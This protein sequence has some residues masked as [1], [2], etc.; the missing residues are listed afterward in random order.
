MR[1]SSVT[2]QENYNDLWRLPSV[3]YRAFLNPPYPTLAGLTGN[4]LRILDLRV[5]TLRSPRA[6]SREPKTKLC[7]DPV[8]CGNGSSAV[9]PRR[10]AVNQRTGVGNT[11]RAN[12]EHAP[13]LRS[14]QKVHGVWIEA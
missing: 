12:G 7:K 5:H 2:S 11:G 4:A 8:E 9:S 3:H 6:L 1:W 10:F 13:I 14:T